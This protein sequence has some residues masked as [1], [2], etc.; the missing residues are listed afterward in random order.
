MKIMKK[1]LSKKIFA[2]LL[3][4]VLI[5]PVVV[6]NGGFE[7]AA[8]APATVSN[9]SWLNVR[10]GPS[11]NYS[12]VTSIQKGTV[13]TA[14]ERYSNGWIKIQLANGTLGYVNGSYLTI[15]SAPQPQPTPTPTQPPSGS[16]TA[17]VINASWLNVRA[18][19]GT[20]YKIVTSVSG[21]TVVT[22]LAGV[23]NGWNKIRLANG[24]EGFVNSYYLKMNTTTTPSPSVPAV[25]TNVTVAPGTTSA[26]VS[27]SAVS[28]ATEYQVNI[29]G[30]WRTTV[31]TS[32][33]YSNLKE[34]TT[35][36]YC[37]RARNAVGYSAWSPSRTFK[38]NTTS[39]AIPPAPARI[40]VGISATTAK[41]SWDSVPG[42]T[43]YDVSVI[44][45]QRNTT[46]TTYTYTNLKP[47]TTYDY[48]VRSRNALGVSAWS[49][50]TTKFTTSK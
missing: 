23:S 32:Y 11:A 29:I 22:V 47:N 39:T 13:V 15:S 50:N 34:N 3:A 24:T 35:Y 4:V 33:T 28:G 14:I 30:D 21:G 18:G 44:G 31:V 41:L 46:D 49:S 45:D 42:A 40:I 1:S 27:W 6:F 36:D 26:K 43:S 16:T 9:A 7:T 8:A 10:S 38:T 5:L 37:V 2:V 19:A 20:N 25:P 12:I 17:T 48:A